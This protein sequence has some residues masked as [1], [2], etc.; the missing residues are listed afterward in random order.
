MKINSITTAAILWLFTAQTGFSQWSTVCATG[1]GF[2]TNFEVFNNELYATGFFTSLCGSPF[3]HLAK[4]DGTSW[5]A[6]GTGHPTAGHQL[7]AIDNELYFVAYQPT[8]DS[9]WVYQWDGTGMNKVGEG[10]YLTTAVTGFSQTANLYGLLKYDG[11]IIACGEFDRVGTKTISGIMQWDGTEWSGLGSGLSGSLGGAPIMYPHDM[12]MFGTDLV[13]GGNFLQAGGITV[14]GIARW[15]G[16]QWQSL[17]DGFNGT[18]YGVCEFNGEL[19]ASGGFTMSGSTPLKNIAKWDGSAWVDP[20]FRMYYQNPGYYSF[21][22]TLKAMNGKLYVSG[23]FDR[24]EMGTTI[25][26]CQGI[27]VYDGTAVDTLS[28][29]TAGK[30]I[31][32]VAL[33]NGELYAGGGMNNSNSFIA[34]Y[35]STVGLESQEKEQLT[36]RPNPSADGIFLLTADERINKIVVVNNVGQLIKTAEP[37]EKEYQLKLTES[38]LYHVMIHLGTTTVHQSVSVTK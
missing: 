27:Y 8:L 14:N 11:N 37:G 7:K 29:G 16:T 22:H 23:G 34:K 26:Q 32:G 3:N 31:E 17:G 19:Y 18:V 15:D 38:G 24:V 20:G 6:I 35:N 13:V 5:T 36:V 25:H 33:Y 1:N 2:V 21:G 12:C 4:F 30:E 10:V 28:G 9:N